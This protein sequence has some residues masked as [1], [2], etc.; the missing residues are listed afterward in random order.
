MKVAILTIADLWDKK[1]S[2]TRNTKPI[3]EAI[4][5][6]WVDYH[7]FAR[8]YKNY[9][10]KNISKVLPFWS[11]IPQFLEWLSRIFPFFSWRKAY[12][13]LMDYIMSKKNLNKY[14]LLITIPTNY[15]LTCQKIKKTW[16]KVLIYEDV[17]HNNS[18][19][20]KN[21]DKKNKF[22]HQ[23]K[24]VL[25]YTDY[26]LTLSP[27]AQDSYLQN[28]WWE[29]KV[30]MTPT[31]T[32]IE[33]F[34]P[35]KKE[36]DVFRVI[37]VANYNER[38]GYQYLL[39]AWEQLDLPNAELII[40]GMPQ[41]KMKKLVKDY[42]NKLDNFKQINFTHDVEKYYQNSSVFILPSLLEGSARVVYEAMAC[43]LPIICTYE[44]GSVVRD[45]KDGFIIPSKDV[46]S[47]KEK[48]TYM[49]N[50][51]G[52]AKQM[53]ENGRK[54]IEKHYQWK[55]F[56]DRVYEVLLDIKNKDFS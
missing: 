37:S 30:Y 36:D 20:L 10:N 24:K 7:I 16:W 29:D 53:W 25:E 1:N 23:R 50:H 17:A 19:H 33:K 8:D 11:L 38:K 56:S 54:L 5:K 12:L 39:K 35:W 43:K 14:D 26:I 48:L 15:P 22:L 45:W 49:Y 9:P 27:F 32:D 34:K 55:N 40:V 28:G 42:E 4:E 13:F 47:I 3:I 52:E 21:F 44:T 46:D 18:D 2:K 6:L 41:W 51:Q 31:W